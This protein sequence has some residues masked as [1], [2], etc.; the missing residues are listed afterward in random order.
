M[1]ELFGT[2]ELTNL[3][4]SMTTILTKTGKLKGIIKIAL[5]EQ[6]SL[7][8][9]IRSQEMQIRWKT[10]IN[11]KFGAQPMIHLHGDS[12]ISQFQMGRSD[13]SKEE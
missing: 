10:N 13:S 3:A 12:K 5:L 7:I 6:S 11:I 9:S 1:T 2:Q 8:P 4:T